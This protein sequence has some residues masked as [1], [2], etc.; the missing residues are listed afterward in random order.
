[1]TTKC[2]K[3]GWLNKE[4]HTVRCLDWF[5]RHVLKSAIVRNP[6]R[7]SD[8][9]IQ[10]NE[11]RPMTTRM[12]NVKFLSSLA[13]LCLLALA[14][15]SALKAAAVPKELLGDWSLELESGDPA[16]MSVVEKDGRPLVHMRVYIG[17][18]GPSGGAGIRL[19]APA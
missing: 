8:R 15:S 19:Q 9:A 1:M 5:N 3:H 14:L 13:I 7:P 11:H 10:Q 2:A 17:P 12:M 16:W 18:D 6:R 4:A